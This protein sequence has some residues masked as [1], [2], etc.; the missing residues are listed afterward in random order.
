MGGLATQSAEIVQLGAA[1]LR[2]P[3]Y[4]DL[5]NDFRVDR[6]DALHTVAEADLADG[7]AGL[8]AVALRDHDAFESLQAFLVAF[9]DL[10]LDTDSVTG[11]ET[12]EIGTFA[13]GKKF[14]NN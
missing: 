4:I 5:V 3:Q 12:R 10:H 1:D 7:E 8:R 2:G 6:E 11:T 14:F 9:L 13:L